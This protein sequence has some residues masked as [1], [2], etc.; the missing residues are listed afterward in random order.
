VATLVQLGSGKPDSFS[1]LSHRVACSCESSSLLFW[2]AVTA[3]SEYPGLGA[4]S[5]VYRRKVSWGAFAV[6]LKTKGTLCPCGHNRVSVFHGSLD[7][8][9]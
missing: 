2:A 3:K 5:H 8:P 4:P 7:A 1:L 6:I 9:N